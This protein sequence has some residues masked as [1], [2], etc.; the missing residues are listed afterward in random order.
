MKP[1]AMHNLDGGSNWKNPWKVWLFLSVSKCFIV[2]GLI[3]KRNK[4]KLVISA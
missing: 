3:Q 1:P 4:T 2:K